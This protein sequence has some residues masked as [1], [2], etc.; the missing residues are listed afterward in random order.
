MIRQ[1][2]KIDEGEA[3]SVAVDYPD[4][5]DKN[6]VSYNWEGLS[7]PSCWDVWFSSRQVLYIASEILKS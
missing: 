6:Q 1:A 2:L 5:V 3:E 7:F 4:R